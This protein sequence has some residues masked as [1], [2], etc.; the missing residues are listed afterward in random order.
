MLPGTDSRRGS[1]GEE[2]LQ[3]LCRPLASCCPPSLSSPP[4]QTPLASLG[5]DHCWTSSCW[6]LACWLAGWLAVLLLLSWLLAPDWCFT[7]VRTCLYTSSVVQFSPK[8][9]RDKCVI[10]AIIPLK[11][12]VKLYT[13]LT[14]H[15]SAVFSLKHFGNFLTVFSSKKGW[16]LYDNR[17]WQTD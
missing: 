17:Q 16:K 10:C 8:N 11:N 6:L 9:S 13:W 4:P 15:C 5:V 2:G 1:S 7:E 3:S 14:N 12:C